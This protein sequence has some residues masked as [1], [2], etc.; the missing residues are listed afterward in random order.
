MVKNRKT[1]ICSY[2]ELGG[3]LFFKGN[4]KFNHK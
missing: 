2:L 1:F 3:S 4:K